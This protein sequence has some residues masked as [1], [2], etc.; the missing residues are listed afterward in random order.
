MSV[1]A[2]PVLPLSL[3]TSAAVTLGWLW[4]FVRR[5]RHPEP[6][7]LLSRTFAWGAF[8]WLVAT[9]FE[10]SL[11]RLLD[12]QTP[13]A[14]LLVAGLAVSAGLAVA[15]GIRGGAIPLPQIPGLPPM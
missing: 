10:A 8:A 5:D 6:L 3:L 9:T 11:G 7:W 12:D 2:V 15:A 14:L 1:L 13:L 4:F